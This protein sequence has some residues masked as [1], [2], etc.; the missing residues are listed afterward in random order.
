[1]FSY[2]TDSLGYQSFKWVSRA[3]VLSLSL[4]DTINGL[5]LV[6]DPFLIPTFGLVFWACA[7]IILNPIIYIYIYIYI[8]ICH[9][10]PNFAIKKM[11]DLLVTKYLQRIRT[12]IKYMNDHYHK[13]TN[14]LEDTY[15]FHYSIYL[16]I[17]NFLIKK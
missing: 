7:P 9:W 8:Y 13:F 17:P 3:L 16:R 12:L 6:L 11:R 14:S 5:L 10:I 15:R 4:R 2:N 1:M